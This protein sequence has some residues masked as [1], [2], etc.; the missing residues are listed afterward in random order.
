MNIFRNRI[1]ELQNKIKEQEEIIKNLEAERDARH[2]IKGM[3]TEAIPMSATE[4]RKYVSDIAL[5]YSTIFK[6]KIPHFIT[7]QQEALSQVGRSEREYDI[8]RSNINCFYLIDDWMQER[9]NEH[10]GDLEESR[11]NAINGEELVDN[12][13][14]KYEN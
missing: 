8:Y 14:T 12:L 7:L 3:L 13:R 11:I 6:N 4:R 5:F 1:P 9:T 2:S 10:F